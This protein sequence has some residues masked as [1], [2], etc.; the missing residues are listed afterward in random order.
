MGFFFFLKPFF[1]C[2]A[3]QREGNSAAAAVEFKG[4]NLLKVVV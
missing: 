1:K 3:E 2:L 4:I